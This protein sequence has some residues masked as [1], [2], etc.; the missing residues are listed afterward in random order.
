MLRRDEIA[1]KRAKLAELKRQRE[2]RQN[3]FSASRQGMDSPSSEVSAE[4][5]V[6]NG[7][8]LTV[9]VVAGSADAE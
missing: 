2:A 6:R 9:V 1:A 4:S 3:A 8:V 7:L 5:P